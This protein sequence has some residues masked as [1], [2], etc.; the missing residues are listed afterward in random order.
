MQIRL[1]VGSRE[2]HVSTI[3]GSMAHNAFSIPAQA[4]LTTPASLK[5]ALIAKAR[6][7]VHSAHRVPKSHPNISSIP[8]T[9]SAQLVQ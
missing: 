2:Q 5:I 3:N 8:Q 4:K 6:Q 1:I 9:A 7:P